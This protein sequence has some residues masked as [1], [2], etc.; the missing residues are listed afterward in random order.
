MR[1]FA[2]G[3]LTT[4]T[5]SAF[6]IHLSFEKLR[7]GCFVGTFQKTLTSSAENQIL[8]STAWILE[9]PAPTIWKA[10]HSQLAGGGA[11]PRTVQELTTNELHIWSSGM[12]QLLPGRFIYLFIFNY[13]FFL[14]PSEGKQLLFVCVINEDSWKKIFSA[15]PG[16]EDLSKM[17]WSFLQFLQEVRVKLCWNLLLTLIYLSGGS[18]FGSMWTE[19]KW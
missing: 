3:L 13:Y 5:M 10:E 8:F 15:L 16:S 1:F 14:A 2:R 6:L 9:C 7:F 12:C 11:V 19:R 18:A 17:C 4:C